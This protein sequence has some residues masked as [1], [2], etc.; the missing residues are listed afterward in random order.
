[1]NNRRTSLLEPRDEGQ[2]Q[3]QQRVQN[4]GAGEE[5]EDRAFKD[6]AINCAFVAVESINQIPYEEYDDP[7]EG[8]DPPEKTMPYDVLHSIAAESV[9]I[10]DDTEITPELTDAYNMVLSQITHAL[11]FLAGGK[12]GAEAA[13]ESVLDE[14]DEQLSKVCLIVDEQLNFR[15]KDDDELAI[16]YI[17]DAPVIFGEAEGEEIAVEKVKKVIRGGKKVLI[18]KKKLR[19]AELAMR[20]KLGRKLGK[21]PR[22]ASAV[23]KAARSRKKGAK[24]GLY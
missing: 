11:G 3:Q 21:K 10:E 16:E 4:F 9:G 13:L 19:G 24:M 14:N 5:Y 18:K 23:K 6:H 22:K 15:G 12:E 20:K 1:M 7:K 2:R 17:L 8:E